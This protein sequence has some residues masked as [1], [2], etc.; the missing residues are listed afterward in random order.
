MFKYK[1]RGQITLFILVSIFIVC[2]NLI[3]FYVFRNY[4]IGK[5]FFIFESPQK[6][7]VNNERKFIQ[8]CLDYS[9]NNTL[10]EMLMQ[11]GY[12]IIENDYVY[13]NRRERIEQ[14]IDGLVKVPIYYDSKF[15]D[16][17]L[18][19][20]IK[21]LEEQFLKGILNEMYS[22]LDYE[23]YEEEEDNSSNAIL[24]I[25]LSNSNI[26]IIIK[27]DKVIVNT[28]LDIK[29][30]FEDKVYVIDK[31]TTS[32]NT[33][34]LKL[35]NLALN[36]TLIQRIYHDVVCIQCNSEL[37]SKY[38]FNLNSYDYYEE[39]GDYVLIYNLK[40]KNSKSNEIFSFAHRIRRNT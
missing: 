14:S 34:F 16:Y 19:P 30:Q 17:S 23:D 18:F 27:D 13:Y 8:E 12:Y 38:D 37:A 21:D 1:K 24:I 7:I 4:E 35:Y 28:L 31:Y 5:N 2:I 6:A 26:G 11:G 15:V 39:N 32:I 9:L 36:M 3:L 22:C 20:S 10:R 33:D 25:N 29:V 40:F